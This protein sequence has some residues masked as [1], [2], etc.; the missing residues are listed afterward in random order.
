MIKNFPCSCSIDTNNLNIETI[1]YKCPATWDLICSGKTKGIF[2][3]DTSLGM[4]WCKEVQPHNIDEL[5]DIGA[6]MRPGVLKCV[7][8]DTNIRLKGYYG[9]NTKFKSISAK[10]LYDIFHNGRKKEKGGKLFSRIIT[11]YD[12]SKHELIH[13]K[14]TNVIY[15]G[16]QEVFK[17][18]FKTRGRH[19][20]ND[21]FY[22]LE[23]TSDHKLLTKRGWIPLSDI[24]I[25]ERVAIVCRK[26]TKNRSKAKL[27]K[28]EEEYQ[29][30]FQDICFAHY[31]Y[32]CIFC[33]WLESTLDV[34]H[35]EGNRKT[36]NH[37]TNLCFMCPN[38]HRL[39]T[40]KI[41]TKEQ[42]LEARK[43]YELPSSE[44]TIWGEFQGYDLIG[45]KDVYDIEVEGPHHNFIA[46]NVIVHNCIMGNK[47]MAQHYAD[48]KNGRE[49]V[50]AYHPIVDECMKSTYS[51][52]LYQE[53]M[54]LLSQRVAGFS[55]SE[56]DILRKAIGKKLAAE[57]AKVKILFATKAKEA[58]ILTDAQIEQ[59]WGWI[60]E[61]QRYSFNKCVAETTILEKENEDLIEIKDIEIG[62]KI[63]TPE[64]NSEVLDKIENGHKE[65]YEITTSGGKTLIC[66][67]DHKILCEDGIE[68]PLSEII[69]LGL[70]I[71]C[72]DD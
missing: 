61:S 26:L 11:S 34:N 42:V 16:K 27:L 28:Q 44:Y 20:S 60:Q 70:K 58:G 45:V 4:H 19:V 24:K 33:D 15:N 32:K 14:I 41:V 71:M 22:N 39:Y 37:Y 55:L 21:K 52:M 5:G 43:K 69:D 23:C 18:K 9:D 67:L 31:E 13:N 6:A 36:N 57:M 46:G 7:S 72:D 53:Q 25:G 62:D 47:N 54:I 56:A 65:L 10:K 50:A 48:R 59:V 2:Q 68:H 12:E 8:S 40:N 64:G 38:H 49:P 1:D 30:R 51:I 63:K 66:T 29:R 3:V 35:I 17:P